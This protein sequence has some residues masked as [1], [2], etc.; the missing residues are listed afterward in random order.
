MELRAAIE[1][2]EAMAPPTLAGD[3]DNVG[4]LL[5]GT[6]PLRRV[7]LAIDLTEPVL[8]EALEHDADLILAYHPPIFRG[9][10]RITAG[11]PAGRVLL[12]CARAGVHVYSPHSALDAARDGMTDWLVGGLGPLAA[13]API[14][15]Q[16]D[17]PE[18]GAGR[19]VTLAAPA[20]LPTLVDRLKAHLG[21]DHVR[22]AGPPELLAGA[23]PVATAAACPGAGG[24]VLAGARRADLW[25]TGELRHHDVLARVARGHAVVLTD[26]THTE[27]GFLSV[28]AGRLAA[29]LGV[30][31]TVSRVDADPLSVW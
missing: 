2:L 6:R 17:D 19:V 20:P 22:V 12:G 8:A 4:L 29:R 26:H 18:V 13:C 15:P 28:L 11:T 16:V 27:R 23:R 7:F 1:V 31:A 21:L 24:S 25:L 9:L 5:E 3:W 30:E 10:K 14:T